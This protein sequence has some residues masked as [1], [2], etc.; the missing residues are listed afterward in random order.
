MFLPPQIPVR[1]AEDD[2]GYVSMRPVVKQT[3]R[4]DELVDLVVSVAGKDA[5]RVRKIFQAGTVVYNGYRYW[6]EPLEAKL[7]EVE[8]LLAPFPQ[9]DANRA[10]E[11]ALVTA[12]LFESGGGA[13]RTI[14]AIS[15]SEAGEKRL[16]G[17]S[18]PWDVILSL[19]R[20]HP[21][22]YEKYSHGRR[23]DL[24]RVT[25]A[26]ENGRELLA[27]MLEV[28]PRGVRHRW[29]ALRPPAAVTFVCRR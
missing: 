12:V 6:W 9:D 26:Y 7:A 14:V 11:V 10:F 24:F 15:P 1:Y 4:L 8:S 27:K 17:R 16:L 19:A 23:A 22:R 2:A 29:S 25:L 5:E 20:S 28:A 21:P 18:S 13:Q 3:F